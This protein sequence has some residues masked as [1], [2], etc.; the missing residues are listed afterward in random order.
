[1]SDSLMPKF[2]LNETELANL[3]GYLETL[4]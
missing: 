2:P 4:K 1:M 3:V